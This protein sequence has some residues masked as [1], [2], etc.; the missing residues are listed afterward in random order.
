[1]ARDPKYDVLFE[2]VQI[3]PKTMRNRFYQVPHC[4]GGGSIRPGAQASNRAMK[5]EGGWAAICT[6]YCSIH[7]ESDDTPRVYASLWDEG[8]VINLRH[9]C[10]SIHKWNSLAGVEMWHGGPHAPCMDSRHV[11]NSPSPYASQFE[12]LT[13]PHEADEDDI[14][15]LIGMYV[16]AAKRAEQAGFDIVYVYGAHSYLPL[17]FLSKF[18]NKRTDKY[19]GSFENRARFWTEA[20]EAV[21]EAVG[22]RCAVVTRFAIDTIIGPDGVESGDDGIKF[23]EHV[24]KHG[25]VDMW[26]VNVADI[27][28]WGEDA[29]PSRFYKANHQRPWVKGVKGVA[30]VPVLTVG[31]VTSP[32]DMVEIIN[33]GQAD[34]I[35]AA[36]TSIADP[37]FP[38]KLEEGRLDDIRECIGCNM[39]ISRWEIGGPP[40]I[41]TQNATAMEEY[42]RGWH[43]EKFEQAKDPCSVLVVGAGPSGMECARVLGMRGYDVHLCEAEKEIGGHVRNVMRLPGLAEWG[44]V[45]TYR[46]IQLDKIKNVEVHTGTRLSVEDVLAYGADKVVVAT[47]SFWASDGHN[48]VTHSNIPGVDASSAQFATPEQVMAGKDVGDRV[49]VLDADGYFMG[50]SLA[51]MMA[52]QGKEVSIV[53]QLAEVGPYTDFTLEAPNIRRMLHEKHIREFTSHWVQDLDPGNEVKVRVHNVWRDG[54]KRTTEPK[55]GELPRRAGTEHEEL[56][57]DTVILVTSRQSNN[58]LFRDLKDRKGEWAKNEIQAVYQVGDCYAPRMIADAIFE[59]HRVAREFE[60]DNPQ[61]P[62]PH[63][64]E[65]QIWG[66]DPMPSVTH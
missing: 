18:Y 5:A 22:G 40:L 43:P 38:K 47:G 13:Y 45:I 24:T 19:G 6:E 34:I 4:N 66:N 29:G 15:R 42:R 37:F 8:D 1:M 60:S 54:Y 31:R 46:E 63:I 16:E 36:R 57:C 35:G 12:N 27:A 65:R 52:D 39:C 21:R 61:Y 55:V 32:D 25:L 33:S 30:K 11:P 62:L 10:D 7:P 20:L 49:I 23:V 17:Q 50:L 14:K 48:G 56:V 58:E 64:R 51:E 41:C 2:P 26:D 53:T 9:M 28:E 3:G 44:R 59:G